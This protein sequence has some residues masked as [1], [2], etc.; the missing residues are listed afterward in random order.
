MLT[1]LNLRITQKVG[2]ITIAQM[3]KL[4]LKE[5]KSLA[6]VIQPLTAMGL[7]KGTS[8]LLDITEMGTRL[9]EIE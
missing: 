8:C 4:R 6:H 3:K 1:H 2:N 9:T 7:H 5:S